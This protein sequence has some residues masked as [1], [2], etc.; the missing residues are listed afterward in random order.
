MG[1]H[2]GH[3][4]TNRRYEQKIS[5]EIPFCYWFTLRCTGCT[6]ARTL[7]AA[8]GSTHDSKFD[9]SSNFPCTS[10]DRKTEKRVKKRLSN[11]GTLRW[12]LQRTLKVVAPPI[13]HP[14]LGSPCRA[15]RCRSAI[16]LGPG[17]YARA[18]GTTERFDSV[19]P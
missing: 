5:E 13:L 2:R 16:S 10:L 14:C 17:L 8:L 11:W 9:A 3:H 7:R 4:L 19:W 12:R 6:L 1:F 15:L 18:K